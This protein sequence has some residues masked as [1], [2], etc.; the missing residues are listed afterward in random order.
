MIYYSIL[1]IYIFLLFFIT[2]QIKNKRNGRVVFFSLVCITIILFQG[3]RSFSVGTDLS[4]YI[5]AY[6]R[7]GIKNLFDLSYMNFEPGYVLLNKLI[8]YFRLDER[9]FLIIISG[10]IQI[11]IFITMYKYSKNPIISILWYFSFGNFIMTFSGLRQSIAMSLCFSAY[12]FIRKKELLMYC[13]ILLF[14]S[15]FHTSALFCL[16][17]YPIYYIKIDKKKLFGVLVIIAFV[18]VLRERIFNFMSALYFGEAKAISTTGAYTMFIIYVFIY[19]ISF[20]KRNPDSE[21][22]GLR[23]ILLILTI[24]YSFASIHDYVTRIGY[25]LTL[26]MT[27]FMP[28]IIECFKIKP[29]YIYYTGCYIIL[30][31]CFFY[32]LGELDTLPFSFM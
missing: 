10:L 24:I 32:F 7:I 21:Y 25:P 14:A 26:Y 28:E 13:L 27:L 3:F 30:I 4:A 8:Y 15:C 23:N 2:N 9:A 16:F 1:I 31:L 29:K 11:P 12:Y 18:F 5:P 6:S 22:M 20:Y 19:C 17:L